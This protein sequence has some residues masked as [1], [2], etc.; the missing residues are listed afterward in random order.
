MCLCACVCVKVNKG[1][2][3]ICRCVLVPGRL[4]QRIYRTMALCWRTHLSQRGEVRGPDRRKITQ[5][6][7][8]LNLRGAM[9]GW[10]EGEIKKKGAGTW[11]KGWKEEETEWLNT[12]RNGG[13]LR[14]VR[15]ETSE[16]N[17]EWKLKV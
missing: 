2:I 9:E 3:V 5:E 10:N 8:S 13:L 15:S 6:Q 17:V 16:L 7:T 11:R 4:Q 1:I 12:R 14:K